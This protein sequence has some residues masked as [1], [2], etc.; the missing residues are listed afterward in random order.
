ML[1]IE[2][3][4]YQHCLYNMR[5][6]AQLHVQWTSFGRSLYWEIN[7]FY[8]PPT[9]LQEGNVFSCVCLFVHK[10]GGG[11]AL[12]LLY[13]PSRSAPGSDPL[14]TSD[15]G[16]HGPFPPSSD[17]WLL[18]LKIF[19][20]FFTWRPPNISTGVRWQLLNHA[21]SLQTGTTHPTGMLSC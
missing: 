6:I 10:G 15:M 21:W 7:Y 2:S 13:S 1:P 8:R 19:S 14:R 3:F 17:I 5:R 12:D 16:P 18:S 9:K 20:N 11:D 4:S